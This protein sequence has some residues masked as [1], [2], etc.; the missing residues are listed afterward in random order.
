MIADRQRHRQPAV[1]RGVTR[2]QPVAQLGRL[3]RVAG[4]ISANTSNACSARGG[5]ALGRAQVA[6]QAPAV[7]AV[8]VAV[9]V[10]GGER[11]GRVA[12]AVEQLEAAPV[13]D[14]GV[15]GHEVA[16]RVHV[17]AHGRACS[18]L[19]RRRASCRERTSEPARWP[20]RPSGRL[21]P[22]HAAVMR[23]D[24][25]SGISTRWPA[26]S[27]TP[28]CYM[29]DRHRC[30]RDGSPS[31][32]AGLLHARPLSPTS[33]G[34]SVPG[35]HH[36][37]NVLE[38]PEVA[39]RDLRLLRRGRARRGGLPLRARQGA[40]RGGA[41]RRDRRG[42]RRARQRAPLRPGGAARR[43]RTCG[44]TWRPRPPARS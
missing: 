13:E 15:G 42:V 8:G 2:V 33:T 24:R 26:G 29:T 7:A 22:R 1:R 35:A 41:R 44:S 12:A 5:L 37:R 14:A 43:R 38:R 20:L 30:S 34:C 9:A 27:S 10:E 18:P 39:D 4:A 32:L 31:A 11:A 19:P 6:L 28:T 21:E 17:D 16:G 3:R 23:H 36:S 25:A 40:P